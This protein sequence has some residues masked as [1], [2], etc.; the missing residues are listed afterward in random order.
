MAIEAITQM[1]EENTAPVEVAGYAL[2]DVLIKAALVVPDDNDGIET[3]FTFYP[4]IHMDAT[5]P[6]WWDFHVSSCSQ[7]GHWNSHMTGTI[8]INARPRHILRQVPPM[9]RKATGKAWNEALRSVGFDYGPSFQ[10]MDDVRSDGERFHAVASS[11]VKTE[12]GMV[13]G[14]SRYVLHPATIDSC[15]QLI[16]VSIYAGKM[17]DMTC[18]AVPTQVS[19]VLIW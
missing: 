18:G 5:G 7:G 16:I 3:L 13:Q 6:S 14:E 15:L 2:R 9:N 11:V 12:S 10:D 19:E 8:G 1:N 17:E 4:S